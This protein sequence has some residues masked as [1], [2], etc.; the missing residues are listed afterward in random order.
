MND[1]RFVFEAYLD[2]NPRTNRFTYHF[3]NDFINRL[4]FR[5]K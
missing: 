1:L 3:I 4:E 5:V 2:V